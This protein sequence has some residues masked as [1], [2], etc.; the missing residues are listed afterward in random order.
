MSS[1]ES[2]SAAEAAFERYR[3]TV[4]RWA[5]P[6]AGGLLLWMGDGSPKAKL[7]A[8]MLFC[9][10][11]WLTEA[12]AL[13]VTALLAAALVVV[14]GLAPAKE[15]FAAFGSP[16]LFLFVGSFFLAEALRRHGLGERLARSLARL[17]RGRLGVL[18]SLSGAAFLI[19]LF[20]SNTAAC[21]VVLPMA[22]SVAEK[23]KDPRY[24]AAL[25]LSIAYGA[26]VG[27]IGTPVGTPPNLIGLGKLRDHGIE[28]SFLDFTARGLPIAV[29]MLLV[30]WG[31]LALRFG[32]RTGQATVVDTAPPRPWSPAE[33]ATAIAFGVAALG[34]V[35]PGVLAAL[36]EASPGWKPAAAWCKA[37]LSEETVSLLAAGLLFLWPT[38]REGQEEGRVLSWEEAARIDWGTVMLFGGGILLGDLADKTGLA[39]DLGEALTSVTGASS[40]FGVTALVTGFSILLSEATSNTA[41]A[42]LMVP[43]SISLANAAGLPPTIPALGATFG[44]SFGF[45]LP[46]STAPNAMAYGTGNV[47]IR[48]MAGAGLWFDLLGFLL[49]LFF[50]TVG[51]APTAPVGR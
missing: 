19:S 22:L 26:S 31:L 23:E 15:A 14:L 25:V 46:I 27:G 30:L 9:G 49:I 51:I 13:P 41:A 4:G 28:L 29:V 50:L 34:W 39:R 48:Q 3:R 38:P 6:L 32:V 10:I 37:R 1:Q 20:I 43:L 18:A 16:L 5:G 17:G 11:W 44:S 33:R 8:V 24:A 7:S 2:I 42:T 40:L 12:V 36:A 35:L 21:A 45:M 47:S